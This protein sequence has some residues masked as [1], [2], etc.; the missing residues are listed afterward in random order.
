MQLKNEPWPFPHFDVICDQLNNRCTASK[1]LFVIKLFTAPFINM[2]TLKFKAQQTNSFFSTIN[3]LFGSSLQLLTTAECAVIKI[4][5]HS[6]DNKAVLGSSYKLGGAAEHLT[7]GSEK[8]KF[9]L[10]FEF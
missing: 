8:C 4:V 5:E 9:Q 10:T 2:Q 7:D 1:N 6:A 3:R